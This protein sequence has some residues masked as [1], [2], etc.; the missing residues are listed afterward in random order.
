M[1]VYVNNLVINSGATF[2]QTFT[3]EDSETNSPLDLT[4]S[5]VS[6]QMRKHANSS[7]Y[8][9][10][11]A[12]IIDAINGKIQIGLNSNVT[13]SIK[14]GRYLYD[15]I[16]TDNENIVTRVVEGMVLVREGVTK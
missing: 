2:D 9:N 6:S 7:S 13:N 16:V 15:I 3:L 10:F 12:T 8:I 5:I 14:P 11:V 4:G 1:A